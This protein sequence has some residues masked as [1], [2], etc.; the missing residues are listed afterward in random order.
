MLR[1]IIFVI[2]IKKACWFCILLTVVF[3]NSF[4]QTGPAGVGTS[5]N[6]VFWLKADAGTSSTVNAV[7]IST[8]NDQSGNSINMSQT[9]SLQQPSFATN[10]INGF[11]AVLFDNSTTANQND[12]MLGADSPLLDNTSGYTFFTATRP[13]NLDG[14]ARSTVCKRTGVSIDQSF[15]IFYYTS[16]KLQ[17]DIQTTDDR[18]S[19]NTTYANNTNYLST[20]I[21]NG[22]LPTA[23]RVA[24]Y[25]EETF[26][27]FAIETNTLVPDNNSPILIGSTD[28]SDGRPYG[29]YISEVIIYREAL[30]NAQRIIMNNYLSAKYNIALSANDKYQGDNSGSGDYDR[31]VAG[32]GQESTGSNP[33]FSASVTGGLTMSATSGLDNGDYIMVGH[34]VPTN[35]TITTDVGGMTGSNKARWQR[36]WCV[37]VTNASTNINVNLEFDMSDGGMPTFTLG[38]MSN[39]V[40]LYRTGQSGNWLEVATPNSIVGDRIFFNNLGALADGYITLGTRDFHNSPLPVQL[41][42]FTAL[43]KNDEVE[44]NWS[45]ANEKN[46]SYFTLERSKDG[47]NF[48]SFATIKGAGNSSSLIHYSNTDL[49]PY[50]GISYYRLKQTDYDGK[51]TYSEIVDV[52]MRKT[53]KELLLYPNPGNGD[54]KLKLPETDTEEI[55]LTIRDVSG[56]ELFSELKI[57][58][59]PDGYFTVYKQ[60]ELIPGTYIVIAKSNN[61]RYS[62]KF[63]IK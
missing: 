20:I 22:T 63:L 55:L 41:V 33:S 13:L 56:K 57:T 16:N 36:I 34:A 23:S 17:V 50:A 11:P 27:K 14:S 44:L 26:D 2:M 54:F 40:L 37:D 35:T 43:P 18:F 10:V 48:E 39:Y 31:E 8:W 25:N 15:M 53:G 60:G 30:G 52:N 38:T 7:P 28:A 45:T 49:D 32:I 42:Q 5:A 1:I 51:S 19:S 61:R 62:Q 21:Y 58:K 12:K 4:S 47:E 59:D 3:L 46:N 29:G 24:T 9:V 6:N